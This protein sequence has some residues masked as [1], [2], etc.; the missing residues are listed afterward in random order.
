MQIEATMRYRLTPVRMAMIRKSANNKSWKTLG[1]FLRKLKTE[2]PYDPAILLLGM[3]LDKA[4]IR[5]DTR[6]PE[7]TGALQWPRHGSNLNVC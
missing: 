2:L 6:T 4:I 5:K 3:Y 7:F 1:S